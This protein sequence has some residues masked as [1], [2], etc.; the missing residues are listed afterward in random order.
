MKT[1]VFTYRDGAGGGKRYIWAASESEAL[2]RLKR[3]LKQYHPTSN[4]Q[5]ELEQVLDK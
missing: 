2:K 4:Y 1:Y 3:M 5:I